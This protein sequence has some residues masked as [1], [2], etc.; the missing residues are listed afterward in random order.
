M[1]EGVGSWRGFCTPRQPFQVPTDEGGSSPIQPAHP[2]T[3][4]CELSSYYCFV[5][6]FAFYFFSH[7]E[8]PVY[9]LS[10]AHQHTCYCQQIIFHFLFLVCFAF[11]SLILDS[12]SLTLYPST[13]S[14]SLPTLSLVSMFTFYTVPHTH[15]LLN[16]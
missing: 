3:T 7:P 11:F 14:H 8:Y 1:E 16:Y 9:C 13:I 12:L 6:C 15:I 5:F 4:C 2:G 10:Q